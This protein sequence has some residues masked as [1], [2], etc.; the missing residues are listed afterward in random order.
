[1]LP[2]L[3]RERLGGTVVVPPVVVGVWTPVMA[4]MT[5]VV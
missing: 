1:V 5:G 4:G 3:R 2:D